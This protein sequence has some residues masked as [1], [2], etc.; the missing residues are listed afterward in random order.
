MEF[1][2]STAAI[3]NHPK[4]VQEEEGSGHMIRIF[5]NVPGKP[6]GFKS[7]SQGLTQVPPRVIPGPLLPIPGI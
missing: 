1:T 4:N 3:L 6:K 5:Q 2:E 7:P